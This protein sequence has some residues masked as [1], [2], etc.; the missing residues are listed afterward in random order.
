MEDLNVWRT[1][2]Q[3]TTWIILVLLFVLPV[4]LIIFIKAP[5]SSCFDGKQNN[6]E[7]GIDCG[8]SCAAVCA[9][10]TAPLSVLWQRAFLLRAG[11]YNFAALVKNSNAQFGA[12]RFSY[13]FSATDA[14]GKTIAEKKGIS[15]MN[16]DEEFIIFEP[17]VALASVPAQV[18][19]EI[20]SVEWKRY[21]NYQKPPLRIAGEAFTE[22]P[23]PRLTARIVNPL[24]QDFSYVE[25]IAEIRGD[26]DEVVAVSRSITE[27]LARES[28]EAIFFQWPQA[29]PE[30]PS[31][32]ARPVEAVLLFD[33]SGSMDDDGANPPQPLTDAKNAALVFVDELSSKDK[34]GLVSFATNATVP[35]EATLLTPQS[36]VKKLISDLTIDTAEQRG[37]TNVGDAIKEGAALFSSADTTSAN[38]PRRV[39]VLLTDGLTNAPLGV[40]AE[41]YAA[42]EAEKAKGQGITLYTIGLGKNVNQTFLRDTIAGSSSNYFF[43]ATSKELTAAYRAIAQDVCPE[44]VYIT[45]ILERTN[46]EVE[47]R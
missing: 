34:V 47:N 5:R 44:K 32:C 8:G 36:L 40:N 33:R 26:D 41:A 30:A 12:A 16:P 13:T 18:F 6:G 37:R 28:E 27:T 31:V 39:I 19:F 14:Q 7:L 17:R 42:E 43:S 15:F 1:R 3:I 10:E 20:E 35:P 22:K 21:T 11:E 2:R 45:R 23:A 4:A 9:V 29:L 46:N 38:A 25:T 24:P